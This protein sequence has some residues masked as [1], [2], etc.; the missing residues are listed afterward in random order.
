MF[1]LLLCVARQLSGNYP[2]NVQWLL[3]V[4]PPVTFKLNV[5]VEWLTFLLRI[6]DI[7]D[8]NLGPETPGRPEIS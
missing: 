6:R 8:S 7:P 3:Y 2:F 5:V 4:P 1:T